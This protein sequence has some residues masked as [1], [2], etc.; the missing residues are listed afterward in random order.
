MSQRPLGRIPLIAPCMQAAPLSHLCTTWMGGT[1]HCT[2]DIGTPAYQCTCRQCVPQ[3]QLLSYILGCAGPPLGQNQK[4]E[5]GRGRLET[6]A[7][8]ATGAV[9]RAAAG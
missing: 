1:H 9:S 6:V 4:A 7:E 8:A 2:K 5:R 3:P